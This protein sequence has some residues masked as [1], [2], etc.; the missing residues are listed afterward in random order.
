MSDP[1]TPGRLEP[2]LIG[3]VTPAISDRLAA[4]AS[5]T[6]ELSGKL[7]P[8]V[9]KEARDLVRIMNCYYSNLIE[10]HHTRPRDIARAL[11]GEFS[12][13]QATRNLQLE[14]SAHIRLQAEIDE[15]ARTDRLPD[16]ASQHFIRHL[17]QAFYAELPDNMLLIR[18]NGIEFMME[19]GAFRSQTIHDNAVGNHLPPSS[20]RVAAFMDRFSEV[21]AADKNNGHALMRAVPAAHHRFAYIHPFPDG[22][23]RVARLMSHAMILKAGY[24]AHGLWSISRGLARRLPDRPGY[25][26]M[27][28]LTD[29]P[30]RG[31]LDGRGNLSLAALR[32]WTEWFLDVCI[33]QV[34]FMAELFDLSN[35]TTR[36]DRIV[37][38]EPNLDPAAANLLRQAAIRGE[39]PRGEAAMITGLKE[40]TARSNLSGLVAMGLLASDTPKGPVRLAFP[41]DRLDVLFPRLYLDI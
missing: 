23:G 41:V 33:D 36:L 31:S 22:N 34:H 11:A 21:Y 5:A 20:S 17:H 12:Q 7:N 27:L 9:A 14:A 28:A 19:P 10:G 1:E 18:G 24:G 26:E 6:T 25:K 29:S 3:D 35:L 4:L 8:L 16:P 40:R 30:R 13:N 2:M 15:Q 37:R 39:I 32:D 38:D